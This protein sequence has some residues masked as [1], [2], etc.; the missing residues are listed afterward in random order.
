[1]YKFADRFN[2]VTGSAIRQIFS[3]LSDP[4]MISFAG[5]NPSPET[6]EGEALSKIAAELLCEQGK[7]ILQYGDT[8][9]TKPLI[10]TVQKL[11]HEEGLE[12]AENEIIILTGSSQGID[13]MTK[14]FCNIGDVVL[15][16]SPTFL[17]AIQTFRLYQAMPVG[18]ETDEYGIDLV[19]LENKI[20]LYSPKFLY[21]IPT[22]QNPSG[23]T[24]S[25]ER[26]KAIVELC[27]KYGVMILE[28]DPYASLRYCGEPQK[29]MKCF[30][31]E[32]M[33]VKLVS[34]SKTISPGLRVGAAVAH[35]DIIAKF[36]MCKQGQDVNS[37]QLNQMLV[38]EY[39]ERGLM[40]ARIRKNIEMYK[41]QMNAMLEAISRE[42]PQDVKTVKPEGGMFI[43]V[44]LPDKIDALELFE[45]A[46][47]RKVAFVPGTHFYAEGGHKNTLRLNFTM[48]SVDKIQKGIKILGELIKERL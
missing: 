20:K 16:E 47:K 34:F 7:T 12:V 48:V 15:V 8:A 30:D 38:R 19:D 13:M 42:F 27:T 35:K 2:G 18:V 4:E 9:G 11:M 45:A 14:T 37:P 46:V 22:F 44:E 10:S 43:W 40:K 24:L 41:E 36:N 28:D 26:R 1:M 3:L 23:R 6:F 33:V 25:S 32:N 21:V 29:A 5:G 17:G 39:I 31:T